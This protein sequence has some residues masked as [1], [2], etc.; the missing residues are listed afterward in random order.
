MS[1]LYIDSKFAQTPNE[2]LYRDDISMKAKGLFAYLQS[3]PQWWDFSIKRISKEIQEWKT[4]TSTGLKELEEKWYLNRTRYRDDRGHWQHKYTLYIEPNPSP[5]EPAPDNPA[6]G[7]ND[8]KVKSNK[9][10]VI[11]KNKINNTKAKALEG[12]SSLSDKKKVSDNSS[13]EKQNSIK[14]LKEEKEKSSAKKEKIT[15]IKE[16]YGDGDI[17]RLLEAIEQELSNFWKI[18]EEWKQERQRAYNWLTAKKIKEKVL[19]K[20]KLIDSIDNRIKIAKRLIRESHSRKYIK[21]ANN[22]Q[23]LYYNWAKIF[24]QV[25][26]S[27]TEKKDDKQKVADLS[28]YDL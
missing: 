11:S 5:D 2:M 8:D 14:Q 19:D 21:K 1:K 17:N 18:Y 23:E 22:M 7:N 28:A 16:E 4:A 6:P 12:A 13:S 24:N 9:Q 25:V 27:W 15:T 26:D 3:K 10:K 20:F